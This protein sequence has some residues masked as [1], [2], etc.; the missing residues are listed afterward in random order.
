MLKA[1]IPYKCF[2]DGQTVQEEMT[3]VVPSTKG[4]NVVLAEMETEDKFPMRKAI[5]VQEVYIDK[6]AVEKALAPV[7]NGLGDK[8]VISAFFHTLHKALDGACMYLR[9]KD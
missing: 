6:D 4:L 7:I 8:L 1:K 3:V 2:K 9:N 5:E